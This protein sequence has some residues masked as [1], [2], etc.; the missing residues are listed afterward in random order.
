MR[1]NIKQ[2]SKPHVIVTEL[3]WNTQPQE[4]YNKKG[5]GYVGLQPT[6][7][8]QQRQGTSNDAS[9]LNVEFRNFLWAENTKWS[10]LGT[11][12]VITWLQ[13]N[14]LTRR[15]TE[16]L[17]YGTKQLTGKTAANKLCQR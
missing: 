14:H 3:Q 5:L 1:E 12:L 8:N 17:T 11:N 2:S 6:E 9:Q 4:H 16:Q 7:T 13:T 15:G 10:S